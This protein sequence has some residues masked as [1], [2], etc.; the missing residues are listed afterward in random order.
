MCCPEE[1]CTFGGWSQSLC[2][3]EWAHNGQWIVF[4]FYSW[5]LTF[6]G[7]VCMYSF[8][9]WP[10]STSYDSGSKEMGW[11]GLTSRSSGKKFNPSTINTVDWLIYQLIWLINKNWLTVLCAI[12]TC[13]CVSRPRVPGRVASWLKASPGKR[14]PIQFNPIPTESEISSH[15]Q[16][17]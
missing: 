11:Q 15:C 6:P 14:V 2:P 13:T 17:A 8:A 4:N 9:R 1:S 10:G 16:Q 5:E 12:C 3:Y 7:L